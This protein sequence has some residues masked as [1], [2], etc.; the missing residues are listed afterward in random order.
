M[1]PIGIGNRVDYQEL[2]CIKGSVANG[3]SRFNLRDFK[4][5]LTLL[6]DVKEDSKKG[7]CI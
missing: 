3:M 7:K 6:T 2:D 1:F 5:L 4:E